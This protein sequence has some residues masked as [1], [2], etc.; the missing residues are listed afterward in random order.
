MRQAAIS[1]I[2]DGDMSNSLE[3]IGLDINQIFSWSI[4]AI[5]TGMPTGTLKVQISNDMVA[6]A[7]S[8]SSPNGP[9]PAAN[10]VNWSDYSNSSLDI[11]SESGDWTWVAQLPPYRW[12]RLVYESTSGSG[13]LSATAFLKGA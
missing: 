9:N 8:N 5:W 3:S 12:I 4:Q 6:V 2:S 13:S 11:T 10:V 1:I 7:A